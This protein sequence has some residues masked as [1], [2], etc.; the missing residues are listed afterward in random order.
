MSPKQLELKIRLKLK[1]LDKAIRAEVHENFGFCPDS[2][3]CNAL[4]KE[5]QAWRDM[6]KLYV[7]KLYAALIKAP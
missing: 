4:L 5:Q 3:K 6:A 7:P 1:M 2:Q